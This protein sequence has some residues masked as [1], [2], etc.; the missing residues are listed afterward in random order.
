VKSKSNVIS[1]FG[2]HEVPIFCVV[3]V[4]STVLSGIE[5]LDSLPVGL[6]TVTTV[7]RFEPLVTVGQGG[8][9]TGIVKSKSRS[10]VHSRAPVH[11]SVVVVF[12]TVT[13]NAGFVS[14]A[15][16]PVTRC[17]LPCAV[18]EGQGIFGGGSLI[19]KSMSISNAQEPLSWFLVVVTATLNIGV[20]QASVP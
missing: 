2:L 7:T 1:Q 13:S 19:S 8:G 15:R 4:T 10:K 12:V 18:N 6:A 14:Q 3:I 16:L 5:A 9:I 17:K 20:A 11:S